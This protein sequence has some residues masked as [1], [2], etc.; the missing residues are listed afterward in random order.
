[1]AFFPQWG[2]SQSVRDKYLPRDK[3]H[4][5]RPLTKEAQALSDKILRCAL[6]GDET[7]IKLQE[8]Y[9][10]QHSHICLAELHKYAQADKK[11]VEGILATWPPELYLC[12]IKFLFAQ[13][14]QHHLP[15]N[16]AKEAISALEKAY[17]TNIISPLQAPF[18]VWNELTT[19]LLN[20]PQFTFDLSILIDAVPH[21]FNQ[22]PLPAWVDLF[23]KCGMRAPLAVFS[24]ILERRN[25][26]HNANLICRAIDH[27]N[28]ENLLRICQPHITYPPKIANHL[29]DT[30]F[31]LCNVLFP[32]SKWISSF[33][34]II[35][36]IY[37]QR[38][39]FLSFQERDRMAY[40]LLRVNS[41]Y[42]LEVYSK[43]VNFFDFP[44]FFRS[45]P[46]DGETLLSCTKLCTLI[47]ERLNIFP[48]ICLGDRV[49]PPSLQ[50]Y[51]ACTASK[52]AILLSLFPNTFPYLSDRELI[53]V[54]EEHIFQL[55]LQRKNPK[56]LA[57][58]RENPMQML[59]LL[60]SKNDFNEKL[61]IVTVVQAL[62]ILSEMV[63]EMKPIPEKFNWAFKDLVKNSLVYFSRCE[64]PIQAGFYWFTT[65]G[66]IAQNAPSLF[67]GITPNESS[68][69][70]LLGAALKAA[71]APGALTMLRAD[72]VNLGLANP[73]LFKDPSLLHPLFAPHQPKHDSAFALAV[74]N[75]FG[76]DPPKP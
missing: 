16:E 61:T 5:I 64:K 37:K 2:C 49:L 75:I 6:I 41:K 17:D 72:V 12:L 13:H 66:E 9:T 57:K 32:T 69:S 19:L 44:L 45:F 71:I 27:C 56:V 43:L 40:W 26:S 70:T 68:F 11:S 74:K 31:K 33:K 55:Y 36:F 63:K 25:E 59:D 1:M 58:L 38:D 21:L 8:K 46:C 52:R 34:Q 20:R 35:A 23:I 15:S 50:S 30:L 10:K 14:L 24:I 4:S 39:G 28:T 48:E 42:L 54:S 47:E 65:M 60:V 29:I 22:T 18:E 73:N 67:H 7:F 62:H 51:E 53:E 76:L 3:T